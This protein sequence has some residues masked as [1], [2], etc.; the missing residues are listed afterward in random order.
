MKAQALLIPSLGCQSTEATCPIPVGPSVDVVTRECVAVRAMHLDGVDGGK[1]LPSK[2]INS[3]RDRLKVLWIDAGTVAT[4]MIEHE[5]IGDRPYQHSIGNAVG[6]VE[7]VSGAEKPVSVWLD[8]ANPNPTSSSSIEVNLRPE[9]FFEGCVGVLVKL[10]G[11]RDSPPGAMQ[12]NAP[13]VTAA[14]SL[15]AVQTARKGT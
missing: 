15:P 14:F 9:S 3:H 7:L 2:D 11:H 6:V 10:E 8:T 1:A 5:P 13:S 4:K 12:P